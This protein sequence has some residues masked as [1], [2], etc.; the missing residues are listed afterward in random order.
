MSLIKKGEGSDGEDY[1]VIKLFPP[2]F[3]LIYQTNN[4]KLFASNIHI[5]IIGYS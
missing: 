3:F 5:P 1:N 4:I 2:D